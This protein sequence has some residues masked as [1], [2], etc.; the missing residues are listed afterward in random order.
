MYDMLLYVLNEYIYLHA[1]IS[2]GLITNSRL[3][4]LSTYWLTFN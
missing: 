2:N 3:N 1:N 4:C